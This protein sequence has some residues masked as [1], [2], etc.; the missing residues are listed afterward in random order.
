MLRIRRTKTG[1][2]KTAIQIVNAG[3]HLIRVVKHLGTAGSQEEIL[4]LEKLGTDYI[5]H[6]QKQPSLFP[7]YIYGTENPEKR[8]LVVAEDLRIGKVTHNFAYEVLC[9]WY[10]I[11]G[12]GKLEN[13]IL[14]DLAVMR[15][16]E[17]VS[18][19][20]SLQLLSEY[21]GI[22]YPKNRIYKELENIVSL[23][24]LVERIACK[25]AKDKLAFDATLVFYDVTTLYFEAFTDDELR[26]SGFSKDNKSHQPQVV[27]GLVVDHLGF[28]LS[29]SVFPGNKFEGHTFIP[30]ILEFKYNHEI[31]EL[32]IVADAAMVS[33]ENMT[34]LSRQGLKYIVA[35]RVANL[36]K[37]SIQEISQ[38]LDR[39]EDKY[40]T[41]NTK[42]GKLI[43]DYSK[44]RASKDKSDRTK[45]WQKAVTQIKYPSQ[46]TK[47]SRFIKTN[48]L[49]LELNDEL[50]VKDELLEGIKGYLTN[51]DTIAEN[52]IVKHY[53][54]LWHVE[55]AFRMAK[56][57]LQARPVYHFKKSSVQAHILIVF[58]SLCLSKAMELA[59]NISI[60][61]IRDSIWKIHDVEL[62]DSNGK[63][64]S[65][66]E[67]HNHP[68]I[69]T[70]LKLP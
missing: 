62:I 28:P 1:S 22:K 42:R 40:F 13:N 17:P 52:L 15:I 47:R 55:K 45:H 25:Y 57:D 18:K 41:S 24:S 70:L 5:F 4:E 9:S 67:N 66:R 7:S 31:R 29:Y 65:K 50:F 3:G 6:H 59:T 10:Q 38:Y 54:D 63:K 61:K 34:E 44:R 2:G 27:I 20:K 35:A 56:S 33:E 51:L 69:H 16:I 53:K 12:F 19:L 32:T 49:E 58:V 36:A 8:H 30:T 64:Y 21:F 14:R 60:A 68:L 48:N 37:E 39:Q 11:C 46:V 23:K 26:K 43:C